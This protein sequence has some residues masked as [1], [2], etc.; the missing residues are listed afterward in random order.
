M[1]LAEAATTQLLSWP[2][3]AS[4]LAH[5][6]RY[7]IS[8]KLANEPDDPSLHEHVAARLGP[9]MVEL[10]SDAICRGTF[11]ADS[12]QLSAGWAFGIGPEKTKK[13][14]PKDPQPA[15]F[16]G[17]LQRLTDKMEEKILGSWSRDLCDASRM[18]WN[19]PC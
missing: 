1:S 12:N 6:L 7:R 14:R 19:L 11:A 3:K 13:L 15:T 17:G 8:P 16:R 5:L 10:V 9:R 18:H 2:E 4:V